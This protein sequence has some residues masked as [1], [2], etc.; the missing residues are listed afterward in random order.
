MSHSDHSVLHLGRQNV[1][2][3]P[4]LDLDSIS[5]AV[6]TTK[7][8]TYIQWSWR[9]KSLRAASSQLPPPS[10]LWTGAGGWQ[11]HALLPWF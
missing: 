3:E 7:C 8:F 9:K 1:K 2:P 10:R 6:H 5:R 4:L 11:F